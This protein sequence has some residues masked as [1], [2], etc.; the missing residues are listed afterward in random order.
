MNIGKISKDFDNKEIISNKEE[1]ESLSFDS[2]IE[3]KY[4][5]LY[6]NFDVKEKKYD[7]WDTI[8]NKINNKIQESNKLN[9]IHHFLEYKNYQIINDNDFSSD[10]KIYNDKAI[11]NNPQKNKNG[12]NKTLFNYFDKNKSMNSI[13]KKDIFTYELDLDENKVYNRLYNRGF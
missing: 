5:K 12:R 3:E 4:N 8:T 10:N 1:N 11:K 2:D 13:T 9:N 6:S 7:F